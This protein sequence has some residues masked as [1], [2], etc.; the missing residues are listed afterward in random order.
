MQSVTFS[1]TFAK[2]MVKKEQQ[3]IFGKT[4]VEPAA[5]WNL[6]C[7]DLGDRGAACGSQQVRTIKPHNSRISLFWLL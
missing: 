4:S 1:G 3:S 2:F 7:V 5:A 6:G